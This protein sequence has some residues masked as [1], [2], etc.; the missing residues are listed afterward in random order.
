MA[1]VEE[2]LLAGEHDLSKERPLRFDPETRQLEQPLY[3]VRAVPDAGWGRTLSQQV[4][5]AQLIG[6]V[7]VA[8]EYRCD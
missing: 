6:T 4:G 8:G 5:V 3:V 2:Y 1:S 7:D